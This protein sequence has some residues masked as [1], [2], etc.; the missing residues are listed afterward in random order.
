MF[1]GRPDCEKYILCMIMSG[2]IVPRILGMSGI[3]WL[4]LDSV[5]QGSGMPGT[6]LI[7]GAHGYCN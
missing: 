3:I 1:C 5:H 4:A 2:M 6:Q 7:L